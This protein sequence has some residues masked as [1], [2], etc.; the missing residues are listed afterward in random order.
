MP[1]KHLLTAL[2]VAVAMPAL[3]RAQETCEQRAQD[4]TAGTVVGALAG[5]LLGGAVSNHSEKTTGAVVG[6]V[7]GAVVGNQLAKGPAD[8]HQAYGWYD[9][10]GRWHSGYANEGAATGYYGRGGRWVYGRPAEYRA[11][12]PPPPLRTD[13]DDRYYDAEFSQAPGYP[14]FR[15]REDHIRFLIRDSVRDDLIDRGDA[16]D[17]LEQLRDI[18]R[19]EAREYQIHGARLPRDDYER[20]SDRLARLDRR[21]DEV[22]RE[23]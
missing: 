21:V 10:A 8:C 23:R 1:N 16:R 2:V 15:D 13:W 12:P 3:A 20:I 17:L 9:N 22:R 6:G 7:A 14:D 19:E 11:P 4:R 18:R 5:A